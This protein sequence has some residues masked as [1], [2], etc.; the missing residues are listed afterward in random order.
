[1]ALCPLSRV[2]IFL[3]IFV[4]F[5]FGVPVVTA[6]D[7]LNS[8]KTAID[9]TRILYL[10]Q[11]GNVNK[12]FSLYREQQKITGDQ[13]FKL[14][15]QM[16]MML[17]EQGFRSEDEETQILSLFGAG[18]SLNEE[19]L[20]LLLEGIQSPS[21]MLQMA[22][23]NLLANHQN[24][25]AD[26]ALNRAMVSNFI[27]I[28]LEAA[29]H[30]AEKKSPRALSQIEAL[31]T[32]LDSELVILFPELY[33]IIG[34]PDAIKILRRLLSHSNEGV[35]VKTILSVAKYQRDDLLPQIRRLA[36]H[37]ETAQQE[38]CAYALGMMKDEF[39][40]KKL[41]MLSQSSS[42]YVSLAALQAQYHLGRKNVRKE[43][44]EAALKNDLFAIQMLGEIE[45]SET[46]LCSLCKSPNIQVRIN[47]AL[48]LLE[49]R[50]SRCLPFVAEI[51]IRD[52]RDLGFIK[53]YSPGKALS[54]WKAIPS[55]KQNFAENPVAHELSLAM[56][57]A[58][59]SQTVELKENEFLRIVNE[60]FENHQNEL[61]PAA[62]QLLE[63]I[64]T[65][66]AI[67][68]LKKY[69]QKAGAP[70]IRNY[71]NLA[72]YCLQEEGPYRDNL[73]QWISKQQDH[74]LI[75]FRPLV[76]WELR[77]DVVAIG[78]SYQLTPQD[79]ST[80]LIKSFEA[81]T[82]MRDDKGID[83]LLDAIQNGNKKNKY[84][85]SGLLMRAIQ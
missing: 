26:L 45:G 50:D 58:V 37:H 48:A 62:V 80:L 32:K 10:M 85:L 27:L 3:L 39:S 77:E 42:P 83:I 84:A 70:L 65:P 29:Y 22:S 6:L 12:A 78:A 53:I 69:Q 49:R 11:S 68:L 2:I 57:E 28:R 76:P 60:I 16:A 34:T 1:M 30:L 81:L 79:M 15:Q 8:G 43:I 46:V 52:S 75:R 41:Q 14:L 61:V 47:A 18:I 21:P 5:P 7:A 20:H 44:E 31:M 74:E 71:C 33:A 38:A 23:L 72:L 64:Q 59:L 4:F 35:R 63:N 40:F 9:G 25:V 56:R 54:A 24:D 82:K 51:L 55:A 13:D 17:Q 73:L 67:A 19:M 66:T 36:T